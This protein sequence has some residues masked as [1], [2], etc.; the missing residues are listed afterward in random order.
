M[1]LADG[2]RTELREV[3]DDRVQKFMRNLRR[4]DKAKLASYIRRTI[5]CAL[6][7]WIFAAAYLIVTPVKFVSK[8]TLILPG[9]GH[10]A[11]LSIDTIG[12]ATTTANSPF[13]S[14]SLSP[15]VVYREIA[16]SDSVRSA[17]A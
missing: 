16:D 5:I 7:A 14:V 1:A 13:G 9:A 6:S 15:K 17:A 12:Q 4:E 11:T 3:V 8:W 2:I 10:N